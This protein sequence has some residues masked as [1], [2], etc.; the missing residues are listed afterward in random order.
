LDL[1]PIFSAS[2][3]ERPIF[4]LGY[5]LNHASNPGLAMRC[6]KN[7]EDIFDLADTSFA[8]PAASV[9]SGTARHGT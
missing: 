5:Q 9:N 7:A 8:D 3:D 1:T 4:A 6:L 2:T